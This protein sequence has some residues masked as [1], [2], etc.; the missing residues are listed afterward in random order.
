LVKTL[1][2]SSEMGP[3]EL[4]APWPHCPSLALLGVFFYKRVRDV[5]HDHTQPFLTDDE[6][7]TFTVCLWIYLSPGLLAILSDRLF[8]LSC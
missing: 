6:V 2:P 8:F 4:L 5:V 1:T 3:I 7:A